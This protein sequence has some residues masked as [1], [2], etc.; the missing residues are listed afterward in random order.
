MR[1]AGGFAT[2]RATRGKKIEQEGGSPTAH[3]FCEPLEGKDLEEENAS[4]KAHTFCEPSEVKIYRRNPSFQ[5]RMPFANH[6]DVDLEREVLV[7]RCIL[8]VRCPRVE[9]FFEEEAA[10]ALKRGMPALSHP[11]A[12]FF[13]RRRW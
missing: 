11:R 8:F 13:S 1:Q 4:P 6:S 9:L 3:I 7:Q 12:M 2:A 10:V 5:R